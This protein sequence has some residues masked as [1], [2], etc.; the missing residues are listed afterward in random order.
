VDSV[1]LAASLHSVPIP[2]GT[3]GIDAA[4][5]VIGNSDRLG[6]GAGDVLCCASRVAHCP[7]R[8]RLCV[9]HADGGLVLLSAAESEFHC[10]AWF[11]A[12]KIIIKG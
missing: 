10:V 3:A 9:A 4:Y 2:E 1:L 11:A 8:T 7:A 12:V 5:M 6:V